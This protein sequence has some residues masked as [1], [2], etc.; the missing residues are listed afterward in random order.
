MKEEATVDM[1]PPAVI[2]QGVRQR[3]RN[4][5][6]SSIIDQVAATTQGPSLVTVQFM[7]PWPGGHLYSSFPQQMPLQSHTTPAYP[8]L[9]NLQPA[10]SLAPTPISDGFHAPSPFAPAMTLTAA[11]SGTEIPEII[12]WFNFLEQRVKKTPHGV[13]LG[14]F[15]PELDARGFVHIS[16]LSRCK[17]DNYCGCEF[18]STQGIL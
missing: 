14:D 8:P 6:G 1:N 7:S 16:Q 17:K 5:S 13:K 18:D 10:Q 15:G 4:V 9:P 11:D 12:P 2:T 3:T